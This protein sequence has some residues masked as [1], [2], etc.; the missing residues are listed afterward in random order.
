M[1]FRLEPITV[2]DRVALAATCLAGA[3]QYGLVTRVAAAAGTS[4]QFV[5]GL[6][7]RARAAVAQALAPGRPGRPPVQRPLVVDARAIERAVLVLHQE[8]RASVR[9]IQACLAGILE[10]PRSVG[11]IQAVLTE[12][13]QRAAALVPAAPRPVAADLD[14]V[15]AAGRPVLEVV[16]RP[17][18]LVVALAPAPGRD[19]TAW[20]STLLDLQAQGVRFGAPAADGAT[21]LRAGVQ[22]AGLPAPRL[23]H[24]HTLRDLGR[25]ART[26]E[27]AAYRAPDRA[28]RAT[29]ALAAEAHRQA[30]G[31]RPQRGRP[32]REAPT[33]AQAAAA[34]ATAEEAVRRADGVAYIAG[35]VRDALRPLDPASGA[36]RTP[37]AVA[38]DL[39][40][41]AALLR[42]LGGRAAAA[43]HL[44]ETR[45][46]AL[47]AY[48]EELQ[49]ALAAPRAALGEAAVA[50][51]GWA[52][53]HRQGLGLPDAAAA[54]PQAP[55]LARAVWAALDGAV[56][57]TGAVEALNSVLAAHRATRRG[58]P[59]TCLALF[60]VYRN[61]HVFA[62]GKRAG[63]SPLELAGL[64]SP[65]WLDALGYGRPAPPAAPAQFRPRP[66]QTV[67]TLAA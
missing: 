51:L 11:A 21:G 35:A 64:P 30:H 33:P 62:R 56:R 29:R 50:F 42:E 10:V 36:A 16:D 15:F 18:G 26:V 1:P 41:A 6:R 55:A 24:W 47:V 45:T 57:G 53:Q 2:A 48:L 39:A 31:R 20:G 43:A 65:D 7:E 49:A 63:H 22:A 60:R 32:L 38:A 67:N 27:A 3:G 9:G 61:H 19:E 34:T 58:L 5:Y 12:A 17:S 59:A 54:W 37:A 14:E 44:L 13:A 23:D 28:E 66:V 40:A 4:R 46:A 52:W 25:H 8:A